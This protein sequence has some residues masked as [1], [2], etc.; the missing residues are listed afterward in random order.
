MGNPVTHYS[1][2]LLELTSDF[3]E[4]LGVCMCARSCSFQLHCLLPVE[5]PLCSLLR[6]CQHLEG[7]CAD[8]AI[9][10][11]VYR[12]WGRGRT[13]TRTLLRQGP[14]CSGRTNPAACILHN[15]LQR[16]I[17]TVHSCQDRCR[18]AAAFTQL[19]VYGF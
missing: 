10:L 6:F 3:L 18:S 15:Y 1:H 8:T 19:E 12:K 16:G 4:N 11:H 7:R 9:N 13:Y 5:P 14:T 17:F 2:S